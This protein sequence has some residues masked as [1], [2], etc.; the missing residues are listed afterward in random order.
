MG[1]KVAAEKDW[2]C[3]D[4]SVQGLDWDWGWD[5]HLGLGWDCHSVE[6]WKVQEVEDLRRQA[7][8][9]LKERDLR[10]VGEATD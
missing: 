10:E 7:E 6:D 3:W 4:C 8:E 2:D 9:G 1:W 5:C